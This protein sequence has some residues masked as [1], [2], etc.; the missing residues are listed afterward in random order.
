MAIIVTDGGYRLYGFGNGDIGIRFDNFP[1]KLLIG[2]N[3]DLCFFCVLGDLV[4]DKGYFSI[5]HGYVASTLKWVY[6]GG[7]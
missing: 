7:L 6:N 4:V 3:V 5:K 1:H 2:T